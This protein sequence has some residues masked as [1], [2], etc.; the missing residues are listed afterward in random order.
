M[1]A[2]HTADSGNALVSIKEVTLHLALLVPG[3]VTVFSGHTT[4]I[5]YCNETT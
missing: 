1:V 2:W 4:L 5:Q 3:W